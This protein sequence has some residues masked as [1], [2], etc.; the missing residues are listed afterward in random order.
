MPGVG[1]AGV[2][3]LLLHGTTRQ[4]FVACEEEID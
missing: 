3:V 2:V 4:A 1:L